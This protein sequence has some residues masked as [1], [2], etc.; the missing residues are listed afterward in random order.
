MNSMNRQLTIPLISRL[1]LVLCALV[2]LGGCE[3]TPGAGSGISFRASAQGNATKTAYGDI[4]GST[5][6]YQMLHWESGDR[7]R[8]YSPQA[9]KIYTDDEHFA[10]YK[11]DGVR[12][13]GT[14]SVAT[15][16]SS[17]DGNGLGWQESGTHYFYSVYPSTD[18]NGSSTITAGSGNAVTVTGTILATQTLS[19]STSG[20]NIVGAPDMDYAYMYAATSTAPQG[21]VALNFNPMFTAFQFE[22]GPG[23]YSSIHLTRFTLSTASGS[24]TL[25]GS[26]TVS[27]VQGSETVTCSTGA[28]TLTVEMDATLTSGHTLTLTVF[29]LPQALTELTITYTGDEIGTRSLGLKKDGEWLNFAGGKKFRIYGLSF[30]HIIGVIG[31]GE[32]ITWGGYIDVVANGEL[33]SWATSRSIN[34][35]GD[36]ITWGGFTN[37]SGSG[38]DSI[39]W[40]GITF[41]NSS[42]ENVSWSSI[43]T[44][45]G[46]ANDVSW[47]GYNDSNASAESITWDQEGNIFTIK[48]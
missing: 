28:T 11:V 12:T 7:I 43:K 21:S 34:A 42:S 18:I 2:L 38:S 25:A 3:K 22:I 27:G 23:E 44:I 29:A 39:A 15:L 26:F 33:I 6:D 5:Q 45:S 4:G 40:G 47:G 48:K 41:V 8:V 17:D 16:L 20:N 30:P 13:D 19:W 10:D 37:I 46:N 32:D 14:T 24:R 35:V 9:V 1:S 36:Y 31:S